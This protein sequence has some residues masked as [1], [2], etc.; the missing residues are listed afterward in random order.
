MF[1]FV[2]KKKIAGLITAFIGLVAVVGASVSSAFAY[3][4]SYDEYRAGSENYGLL[5]CEGDASLDVKKLKLTFDIPSLP[6][7]ND[8]TDINYRSKVTSEYTLY[9]PAD[10]AVTARLLVPELEKPNYFGENPE[11]VPVI[12]VNGEGVQTTVRHL[13]YESYGRREGV[14]L[15]NDWYSDGFFNPDLPVHTYKITGNA[16]LTSAYLEGDIITDFTKAR[17]ITNA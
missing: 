3:K 2:G 16:N 6:Q 7:V 17:Y 9:N 10:E 14:T 12:K 15:L 11:V 1:K 4:P 8:G 5:R 13:A